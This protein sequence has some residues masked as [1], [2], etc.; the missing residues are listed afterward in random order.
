[1]YI[2]IRDGYRNPVPLWH[3]FPYDRYL[4]YRIKTHISV[5]HFGGTLKYNEL[6]LRGIPVLEKYRA[7]L[8][9]KTVLYHIH[10]VSVL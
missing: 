10:L 2:C 3:R 7:T 5:P 6:G 4:R 8:P 1:M 9:L